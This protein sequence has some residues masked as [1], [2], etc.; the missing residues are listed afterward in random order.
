MLT[1]HRTLEALNSLLFGRK[2]ARA[3]PRLIL[4]LAISQTI[5]MT[6]LCLKAKVR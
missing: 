3:H 5:I 6:R 4:L 2:V 1:I